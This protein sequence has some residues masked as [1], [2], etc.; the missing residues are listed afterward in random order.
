MYMYTQLTRWI[1]YKARVKLRG[2]PQPYAHGPY[3]S[4]VIAHFTPFT[5]FCSV[6]DTSILFL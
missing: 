2:L 3:L 4:Q 6:I 1:W 5:I